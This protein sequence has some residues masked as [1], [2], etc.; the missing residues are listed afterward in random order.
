M[1]KKPSEA[2][3]V[4]SRYLYSNGYNSREISR[5]LES[6]ILKTIKDASIPKWQIT[7]DRYANTA[8]KYPLIEVESI[9]ISKSELE[10]IS[11]LNS[12]PLKRLAFTLLCIAKFYNISNPNNNNWVNRTDKEIFKLANIQ[13]PT[14]KQSLMM[15]DLYTAGL[16]GYSKIVDN[17]NINVKFI[18]N[19]SDI[20]LYIF[21]FRNLGYQYLKLEGDSTFIE[22]E[23]CG[24]IIKKTSNRTK[25][26]KD[27]AIDINR[28]RAVNRWKNSIAS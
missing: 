5:Y 4:I 25:Y 20:A 12:K 23:S 14:I 15:N 27:C 8:S 7:I 26:C 17:I 10:V 21:D 19:S 16:I 13:V 3:S 11:K 18:D 24:L 9:P 22:C 2:L 28:K 1:T 6:Y